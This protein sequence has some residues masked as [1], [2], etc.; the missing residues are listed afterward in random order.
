[1]CFSICMSGL[2]VCVF[3]SVSVALS[4]AV[5]CCFD[6][7]DSP[8][9]VCVCQALKQTHVTASLQSPESVVSLQH[10]TDHISLLHLNV[11]IRNSEEPLTGSRFCR[12]VVLWSV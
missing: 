7:V 3:P 9:T 2:F 1:M 8:E 5:D 11:L 4:L 6:H 12:A 10:N